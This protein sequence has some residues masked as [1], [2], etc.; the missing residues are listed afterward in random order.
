MRFLIYA[1]VVVGLGWF[2]AAHNTGVLS[3]IAVGLLLLSLVEN[4]A[5]GQLV[6]INFQ[7]SAH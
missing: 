2:A 4:G 6:E 3:A 5:S 7:P 1:T